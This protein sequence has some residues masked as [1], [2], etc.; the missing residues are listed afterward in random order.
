MNQRQ[1]EVQQAHLDEEKAIIRRL[2]QIYEQ[3]A[4]DCEQK[5]QQLSSRRDLANL[6]TIIYQKQYQ[7]ALKKQLE[8]ILDSMNT[9]EFTS[10]AQYLEKCYENGFFG[11]LYDLHGQGIPLILPID[12][13]Q[14]VRAV[15]T[16]SKLSEGLYSR[17]GEDTK[18][19]K[20]TIQTEL[21]RGIAN[22]SSWL[23]MA[24]YIAEAMKSP[25]NKALNNAIRIARTEGHRIQNQ[26]AL[27]NQY[28]AKEA[29]A[30]IVKQ[31]DSTLDKRTR[32]HHQQ[33][34][35]Q[36]REIDEEFEISGRKAMAPGLFGV[37]EEDINCRCCLSQRAKYA[38]DEDELDTLKER[39]AYFGLDKTKDFKKKKKKISKDKLKGDDEYQ[40]RIKKRR[41]AY[42]RR[43]QKEDS[44]A[45]EK[46]D[47][48]ELELWAKDHLKTQV[49]TLKGINMDYA[50]D[51]VK[52]LSEFEDKMGGKTID[53]LKIKFGGLN[54]NVYAK[55]D[56]KTK[57]LILK[58]SGN[59]EAFEKSQK[60]ANIKYRYKWKTDKD[61]YSTE[62]YTG[63]IWHEIGHA[64][65]IDTGQ[66]LSRQLSSNT[67]IDSLSVKISGY[68][69]TT[70]GVRVSKRSE[71][72]AENFA[73]YMD[74]DITRKKVPQEIANIIEKYFKSMI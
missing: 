72:W 22:G 60:E 14:V 49:H 64:V 38:L 1:K 23:D 56:D 41:E 3:A 27:D 43:K 67:E 63:T 69:G 52:V 68:A 28:R 11:N 10:I 13:K 34:D 19:L 50:R 55:Y 29:G 40:E 33:L 58:K 45:F 24:A 73:A 48:K 12:Q 42:R 70:G 26:A 66:R 62:T 32:P 8:G 36:L 44:H 31:W 51:A 47:R 20:K 21:S 2:K 35:G 16:D 4:E 15:Q 6:Q 5:I 74:S 71:A 37:A 54:G 53:G 39:A 30:D 9:E 59:K 25:Y 7:E 61:Y 65:D 18:Q 57:T 46:M 17:L